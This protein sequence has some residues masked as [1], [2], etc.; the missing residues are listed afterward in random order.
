M[1]DAMDLVTGK[2]DH[3]GV[4]FY[5]GTEFPNFNSAVLRSVELEITHY[6][7][8]QNPEVSYILSQAEPPVLYGPVEALV[9]MGF[10]EENAEAAAARRRERE[11]E[12]WHHV[13]D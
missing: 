11:R 9:T 2:R 5:P 4:I 10:A 1:R 8:V 3:F 6:Q 12:A 7:Y 13:R